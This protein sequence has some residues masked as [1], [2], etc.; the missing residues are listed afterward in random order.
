MSWVI[1]F[2]CRLRLSRHTAE[3]S[4]HDERRAE[5]PEATER[6]LVLDH[7]VEYVVMIK[8]MHERMMA[9]LPPAKRQRA[10]QGP[11]E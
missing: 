2:Q 4:Q 5:R 1:S 8:Q 6:S 9:F 7:R 11:L 10:D 3:A